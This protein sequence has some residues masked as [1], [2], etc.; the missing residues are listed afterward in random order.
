MHSLLMKAAILSFSSLA[1]VACGG[2][3]S[4]GGN[5]SDLSDASGLT[6]Y[7]GNLEGTRL[8]G[9]ELVA[10]V[11]PVELHSEG[12][13]TFGNDG[14]I[15]V[16]F[17]QCVEIK[18]KAP[19]YVPGTTSWDLDI[20]ELTEHTYDNGCVGNLNQTKP[21]TIAT[22]DSGEVA[23]SFF[24]RIEGEVGRTIEGVSVYFSNGNLEQRIDILNGK[25]I[26]D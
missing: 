3:G 24:P 26:P 15:L 19:G 13:L 16:P 17:F 2:N 4:G 8:D 21:G 23:I 1:L 10:S 18:T 7:S 12:G 5:S 11:I 6:I 9:R 25:F 22:T 14:S 20:S